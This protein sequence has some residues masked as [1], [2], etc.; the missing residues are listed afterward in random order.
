MSETLAG[1]EFSWV[2]AVIL[3]LDGT[4]YSQRKLRARMLVELLV[5]TS[6]TGPKTLRIL[7]S[8]R[9]MREALGTSMASNVHELQYSLVADRLGLS[10]DEVKA[11][12]DEW[13]YRRPLKYLKDA[14]R[15]GVIEFVD[16]LRAAGV[17]IAVLSDYPVNEKLAALQVVPD[18]SYFTLEEPAGLL[19]PSPY[20]L[21]AVLAKLRLEPAECLLIG[22]RAD[23]DGACA[24]VVGIRFLLCDKPDLFVRLCS[25]RWQGAGLGNE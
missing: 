10:I 13:I 22:D 4:L 17:K 20:G 12:V 1:E 5:W 18:F 9:K 3:D 19:K 24:D 21:K 16:R 8:F 25:Y 14:R 6:S 23:R 7:R 11:Q 15:N 2:R